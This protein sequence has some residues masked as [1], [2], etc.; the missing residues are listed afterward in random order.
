MLN[1]TVSN[2]RPRLSHGLTSSRSSGSQ[3]ILDRVS[4]VVPIRLPYDL[5]LKPYNFATDH[6]WL[7]DK[8]FPGQDDYGDTLEQS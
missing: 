4:G 6:V 1:A 5:P 3:D 7:S 2:P 8:F